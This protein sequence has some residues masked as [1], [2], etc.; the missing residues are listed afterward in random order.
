MRKTYVCPLY[1]SLEILRSYYRWLCHR[2]PRRSQFAAI[3]LLLRFFG[4]SV[5]RQWLVR[6]DLIRLYSSTS[7]SRSILKSIRLSVAGWPTTCGLPFTGHVTTSRVHFL[8][9][10]CRQS[11]AWASHSR[12]ALTQSE[13]LCVSGHLRCSY[14][15]VYCKTS[16]DGLWR[17]SWRPDGKTAGPFP[18]SWGTRL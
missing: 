14:L 4:L 8:A 5:A 10:G 1:Q 3:D 2:Q 15:D 12:S 13:D 6:S 11:T 7:C 18:D 16:F 9:L 17:T